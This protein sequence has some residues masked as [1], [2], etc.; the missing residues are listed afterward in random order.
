MSRS[1]CGGGRDPEKVSR[2]WVFRGTRVLIVEAGRREDGGAV[3]VVR[4]SSHA[5]ASRAE[6]GR[7][8][9]SMR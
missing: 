3:R 7:L 6:A 4:P 9:A 5:P 2:S 1:A 8:S